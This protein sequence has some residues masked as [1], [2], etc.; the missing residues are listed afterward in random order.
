MGNIERHREPNE[1]LQFYYDI[2]GIIKRAK[3]EGLPVEQLKLRETGDEREVILS[4]IKKVGDIV[5]I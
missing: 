2:K 4:V 3:K 5:E 1:P